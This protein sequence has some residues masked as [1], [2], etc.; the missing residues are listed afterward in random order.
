[1]SKW[2]YNKGLQ[3]IGPGAYAYL[4][5]DGSWGWNNAGLI[6]DGDQSLLVDTLFGLKLTGE[7]LATMAD[8]IPAAQNINILVNTHNDADHIFGNQLVKGAHILASKAAADEFLNVTPEDYRKIFGNWQELGAGAHYI[9]EN[10]ALTVED[11]AGVV[12]TLPHETFLKEKRLKVGDKDVILTAVGP[13]HSSGDVLVHSVQDRVVYTGDLLFNQSFPVLWEGSIEGWI[14]ACDHILSLD[15]DVVM[16][17]HGPI[18]EKSNIVEFRDFMVRFRAETRA[19]FDAGLSIMDAA[20]EISELPDLPDWDLPERII[21]A[22][23]FLYRRYGSPEAT[24]NFL[25]IYG[26]FDRFLD[27]RAK[28]A[29]ADHSAC[30]HSH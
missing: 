7:M 20:L 8:A 26:L 13:A 5:P 17:G 18:A 2:A 4:Q 27:K 23:N 14:A 10:C 28:R 19:R 12:V 9:H 30:G 11:A 21:G 6:T 16:P 1:M 25:E 3:E 15:V 29:A 24:G 22:V